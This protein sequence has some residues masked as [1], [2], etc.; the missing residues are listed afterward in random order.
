MTADRVS[1]DR[2]AGYYDATRGLPDDT[3]GELAD[4]A[5]R[6]PAAA[7]GGAASIIAVHNVLYARVMY[8]DNGREPRP[9]ARTRRWNP[10]YRSYQDQMRCPA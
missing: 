10:A 5:P 2:A 7:V 4:L 8:R 6:R 3:R 1:F 9:A